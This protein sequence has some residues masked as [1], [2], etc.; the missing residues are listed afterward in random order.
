M[1]K[2]GKWSVLV[3]GILTAG[4][5]DWSHARQELLANDS[6]VQEQSGLDIGVTERRRHRC[7]RHRRGGRR[8]ESTI[9]IDVVQFRSCIEATRTMA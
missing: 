8:L 4:P 5:M 9:E 1:S 6:A 7:H 2:V 3:L